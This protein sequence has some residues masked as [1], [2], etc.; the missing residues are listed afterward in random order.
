MALQYQQIEVTSYCHAVTGGCVVVIA[1]TMINNATVAIAASVIVPRCILTAAAVAQ[2]RFARC[3][4][5]R[6]RR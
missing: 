4:H 2:A 3:G 5:P 1:I 6:R